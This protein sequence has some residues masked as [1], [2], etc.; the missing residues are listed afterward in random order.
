MY[1]FLPAT[2][3]SPQKL[4]ANLDSENW[5]NK[6]LP[7][8]SDRKGTLVF[9]KFKLDYDVLLNNSLETL[10]MKR[11]FVE[12]G[13]DFS[14]MVDNDNLFITIV[15]QKSFVDVNEEGP[16]AA[17]VTTVRLSDSVMPVRPPK[18]FEMIMDR[19]FLF[20][21]GDDQ[22]KSILFMGVIYDPAG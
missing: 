11:A 9:P 3:S 21:I 7:Q 1:L 15:K 17:A 13:A 14:R 6:I 16:E 19:P 4:L 10:G 2:N 12:G 8:F 22:T 18:P 20:V 5:H